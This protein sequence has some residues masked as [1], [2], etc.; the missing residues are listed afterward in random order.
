MRN[1]DNCRIAV[2]ARSRQLASRF[3]KPD[4]RLVKPAWM[5]LKSLFLNSS[6]SAIA[7]WRVALT[8]SAL[9]LV[10]HVGSAQE[11]DDELP[12]TPKTNGLKAL[13]DI[14]K[15]GTVD[16]TARLYLDDNGKPVLVP[17]ETMA[18]FIQKTRA[19]QAESRM[20]DFR[21]R[22]SG[23]QSR[24]CRRTSQHHRRV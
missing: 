10:T 3:A 23:R 4:S 19:L 17:S 9:L 2:F 1:I 24:G 5:V 7:F 20:P 18:S 16:T 21:V 14:L 6:L 8:L 13:P 15:D 12:E 22:F 11:P